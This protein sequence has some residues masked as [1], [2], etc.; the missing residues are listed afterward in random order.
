MT[1]I[2]DATKDWDD[3]GSSLMH[4]EEPQRTE[5][6]KDRESEDDMAF[7]TSIWRDWD[8]TRETLG[9]EV[10]HNRES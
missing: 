2:E 6:Q 3:V 7:E 10:K 5:V 4:R 1:L 8:N 9:I